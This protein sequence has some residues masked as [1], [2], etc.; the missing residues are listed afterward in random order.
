MRVLFF[1][2]RF[3]PFK[4]GLENFVFELSKRL[5]KFGCDVGVVTLMTEPKTKHYEVID[6]I[7]VYRFPCK[8][9]VKGTYDTPDFLS[10][11]YGVMCDMVHFEKWDF[12]VSNTRFFITSTWCAVLAKKYGK[13]HIHIE[14][15]CSFVQHENKL[16]QLM[17]W[18]YDQTLGR[19]CISSAS[20]VI[21]IGSKCCEFAK[22]LGAK[23]TE[24]VYNSIDHLFWSRK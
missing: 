12:F 15:G 20:L 17:A 7:K 16:I 22:K 13:K 21:G 11:K 5:V 10:H 2:S 24:I 1:C 6:G 4:G 23:R 14:H 8:E 18:F 19:Y 3:F 9:L